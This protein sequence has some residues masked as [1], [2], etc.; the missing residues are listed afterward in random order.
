MTGLT[1]R[2]IHGNAER[3]RR[4]TNCISFLNNL[5]TSQIQFFIHKLLT[6]VKNRFDMPQ[7]ICKSSKYVEFRLTLPADPCSLVSNFA[8]SD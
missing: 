5:G 8:Y 6:I 2:H 3:M 4:I 1:I 7:S